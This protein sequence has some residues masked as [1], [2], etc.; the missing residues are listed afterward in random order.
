MRKRQVEE[1]SMRVGLSRRE[2]A[3]CQPKLIFGV[4]WISNR[5]G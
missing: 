3:F 5:L 1:E 2:D 4:N